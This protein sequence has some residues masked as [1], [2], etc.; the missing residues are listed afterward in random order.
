MHVLGYSDKKWHG[1]G[2]RWK[3]P[4]AKPL[5]HNHKGNTTACNWAVLVWEQNL[6]ADSRACKS[7]VQAAN[8]KQHNA[9]GL[10]RIIKD[11]ILVLFIRMIDEVCFLSTKHVG[12]HC[13]QSNIFF[14]TSLMMHYQNIARTNF[15]SF[16][17]IHYDH[18]SATRSHRKTCMTMQEN[19]YPQNLCLSSCYP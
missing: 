9:I 12:L 19:N 6:F 15:L 10:A 16:E 1:I 5:S 18:F 7:L 3:C 2:I 13:L 8:N 4:R 11:H 14:T 17:I